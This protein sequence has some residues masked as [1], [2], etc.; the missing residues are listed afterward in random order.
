MDNFK[1]KSIVN[2]L[3]DCQ[4]SNIERSVYLKKNEVVK[5]IVVTFN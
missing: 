1:T 2:I 4:N 5:C 3:N